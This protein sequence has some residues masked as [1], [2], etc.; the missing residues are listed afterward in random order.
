MPINNSE[1][2]VSNKIK[3]EVTKVNLNLVRMVNKRSH[4]VTFS[5]HRKGAKKATNVIFITPKINRNTKEDLVVQEVVEE[6]FR[7]KTS[8]KHSKVKD[9]NILSQL[10]KCHTCLEEVRVALNKEKGKRNVNSELIVRKRI[11]A[12]TDIQ[13][14]K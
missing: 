10:L 2:V 5:Y 6:D 12:Y 9:N 4:C 3:V 1:A 11:L 13:G 7:I 14:K 8:N